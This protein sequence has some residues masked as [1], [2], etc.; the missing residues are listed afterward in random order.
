MSGLQREL[1]VGRAGDG[2]V[3]IEPPILGL[4]GRSAA[5][6]QML[7]RTGF[8][9]ARGCIGAV[10]VLL[11]PGEM[12]RF[13]REGRPDSAAWVLVCEAGRA[14]GGDWRVESEA[15]FAC[16]PEEFQPV[17]PNTRENPG[18]TSCVRILRSVD[19]NITCVELPFVLDHLTRR[20][21]AV[22]REFQ[23]SGKWNPSWGTGPASGEAAPVSGRK[24]R[25]PSA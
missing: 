7:E 23:T 5:W 22:P 25:D 14:P 8:P 11:H 21:K 10:T 18:R 19:A 4:V 16:G 3:A 6:E 9:F 1:T 2:P 13:P 24:P 15:T 17:A 12:P 20:Q